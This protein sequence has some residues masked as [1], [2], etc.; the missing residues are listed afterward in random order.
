MQINNLIDLPVVANNGGK[1][2]K[3]GVV[4]DVLF[5][6]ATLKIA[7]FVITTGGII[8]VRNY[9]PYTKSVVIEGACIRIPNK[10]CITKSLRRS[11]PLAASYQKDLQGRR[12]MRNGS[13]LGRISNAAFGAELGEIV[14]LEVS[15]GFTEDLL[16]GRG[17]VTLA[18]NVSFQE[19]DIFLSD[20]KGEPSK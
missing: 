16:K 10:S 15:D 14:Q 17:S 7:A 11:H 20:M 3:L 4:T 1:E 6:K 8:P 5:D 12:L 9:L 13:R 18:K 2:K 19:K